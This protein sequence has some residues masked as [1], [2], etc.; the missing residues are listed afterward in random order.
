MKASLTLL[1]LV[2]FLVESMPA[3]AASAVP[4]AIDC[5][6]WTWE[7]FLDKARPIQFARFKQ[8][9]D[10]GEGLYSYSL[11]VYDVV[12]GRK[13]R[14]YYRPK[15]TVQVQLK[16]DLE[17]GYL[18]SPEKDSNATIVIRAHLNKRCRIQLP[19]T[20]YKMKGQVGRL[21]DQ[22]TDSMPSVE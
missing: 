22:T 8:V 1:L 3:Y 5:A 2:S 10:L 7:P 14:M 15:P 12:W 11:T 18:N 9:S 19:E 17:T 13:E 21:D 4:K 16:V 6:E 20:G